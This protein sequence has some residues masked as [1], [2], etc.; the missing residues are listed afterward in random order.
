MRIRNSSVSEYKEKTTIVYY[1]DANTQSSTCVTVN[2]RV[3]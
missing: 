3:K 2:V 1:L